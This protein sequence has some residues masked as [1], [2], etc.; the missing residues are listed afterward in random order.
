MLSNLSLKISKSGQNSEAVSKMPLG[1]YLRKYRKKEGLGGRTCPCYS[2]FQATLGVCYLFQSS[3]KNT[4]DSILTVDWGHWGVTR[5][6]SFP[7]SL[8]FGQSSCTFSFTGSCHMA[9]RTTTSW[10]SGP[11]PPASQAC[12]HESFSMD[13]GT[14]SLCM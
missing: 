7:G 3:R 12:P 11:S 1:A 13:P 9:M 5:P 8:L 2:G 4:I 14:H 10:C 6:H